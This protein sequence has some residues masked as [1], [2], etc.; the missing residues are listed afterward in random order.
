MGPRTGPHSHPGPPSVTRGQPLAS[1]NTPNLCTC[2]F[3]YLE[4]SFPRGSSSPSKGQLGGHLLRQ[5]HR[6]HPPHFPVLTSH[7]HT[8]LFTELVSEAAVINVMSLSPTKL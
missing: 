1:P 7:P 3:F 4:S 2:Y 5:P 8:V 6:D